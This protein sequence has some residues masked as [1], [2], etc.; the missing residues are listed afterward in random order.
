MATLKMPTYDTE[1][2][3]ATGGFPYGIFVELDTTISE[4]ILHIHHSNEI[5]NGIVNIT[6]AISKITQMAHRQYLIIKYPI[7][8]CEFVSAVDPYIELIQKSGIIIYLAPHEDVTYL[9]TDGDVTVTGMQSIM[10]KLISIT[11]FSQ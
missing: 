10:A 9:I 6:R 8:D 1:L 11:K 2:L 3:N 5:H 4:P 7:T